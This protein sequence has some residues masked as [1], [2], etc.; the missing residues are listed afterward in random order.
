MTN[1]P[2]VSRALARGGLRPLPA[3]T[4]RNREGIR[5]GRTSIPGVVSV[6]A[7][8]DSDATAARRSEAAAEI[9]VEQGF[10]VERHASNRFRVRR[11]QT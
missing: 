5:V 4:S 7:D 2:A 6:V 1:A 10:T 9:L 8:F 11:E 3:E